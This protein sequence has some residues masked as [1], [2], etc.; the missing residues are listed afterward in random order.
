M[1]VKVRIK[2]VYFYPQNEVWNLAS[3]GPS[4]ALAQCVGSETV[5]VVEV[6]A[7]LVPFVVAKNVV[8]SSGLSNVGSFTTGGGGVGVESAKGGFRGR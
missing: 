5:I 3:G 6:S 2:T 4:L 8:M 7:R 1:G